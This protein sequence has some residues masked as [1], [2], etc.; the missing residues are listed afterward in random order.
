MDRPKKNVSSIG[1]YTY[2]RPQTYEIH[3][4]QFCCFNLYD[5]RKDVH[6]S[7]V[8]VQCFSHKLGNKKYLFTK[9]RTLFKPSVITFLRKLT[10]HLAFFPGFFTN[11]FRLSF[12]LGFWPDFI[13]F[14]SRSFF[15][16]L[17][18]FLKTSDLSIGAIILP[19]AV[20]SF[21]FTSS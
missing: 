14:C 3:A 9:K 12:L 1:I 18:W 16:L 10:N 5:N 15:T 11:F 6:W 20:T 8:Q 7:F 19:M 2:N 13:C 21:G 4:L 17:F